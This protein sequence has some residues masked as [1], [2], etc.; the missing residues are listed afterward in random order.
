MNIKELIGWRETCFFCQGEL[1]I[2]PEV[3]G[4]SAKYS[5]QDDWLKLESKFLNFSVHTVTGDVIE[6]PGQESTIDAFL[7]RQSLRICF[8]CVD[9]EQA[10]RRYKYAGHVRLLPFTNRS[11]GITAF[12]EELHIAGKWFFRQFKDEGESIGTLR[13]WRNPAREGAAPYSVVD[14]LGNSAIKTPYL[15]L[16]RLSPE[17]LE[18]KLKTYIVFS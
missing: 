13:A 9:C 6:P 16:K 3:G 11:T 8:Q 15:D 7:K 18:N 1:S 4:L 10:G 17:K 14:Q 2:F 12:E 5:I